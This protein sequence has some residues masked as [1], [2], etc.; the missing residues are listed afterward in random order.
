MPKKQSTAAKKARSVQDSTGGKYTALLAAQVCG[1]D[2]D[3]FGVYPGTCVREPHPDTEPCSPTRDFD[4]AGW[5][6]RESVR[7]AEA[8]A[9]WEAMTPQEREEAEGTACEMGYDD[10]PL[11]GDLD[12]YR[13]GH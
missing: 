11:L 3:P 7:A 4:L 2:L 5:K 12:D 6:E 10:E 9:R 13:W 1:E 8:R